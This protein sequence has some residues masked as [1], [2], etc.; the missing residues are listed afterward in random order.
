MSMKKSN[1]T[2]RNRARDLQA[3]SAVSFILDYDKNTNGWCLRPK[4]DANPD[5]P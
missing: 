1:D 2:I 3:C 4:T 5:S